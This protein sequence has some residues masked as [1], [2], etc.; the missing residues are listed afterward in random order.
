MAIVQIII[1]GKNESGGAFNS[2]RKDVDLLD[3]AVGKL[4]SGLA[5]LGLSFSAIKLFDLAKEAAMLNARYTT[6]GVTMQVVG[7][8]AGYTA[9]EMAR[10]EQQLQKN[11]IAMIES[12]ETLTKMAS[13]H[14]DLAE[15]AKLS[16]VA[17]DAAVIGGINSS[18]AFNRMVDG[19][20]SGEVEI[21]KTIGINVNF[22]QSYKKLA[23][24]LG[25]TSDELTE[26][27]KVMARTNAVIEKGA[28]IAGAYEAA[29]GT[30]GK[31]V[32]SMQR[33]IDNLKVTAGEVFQDLLIVAVTQ[34]TGALK[35]ANTEA[36]RLQQEGKLKE[37]GRDVVIAMAM[38]ADAVRIV[39]NLV[40]TVTSTA[41]AGAMQIYALGSAAVAVA[42]GDL[43]GAKRSLDEF[44]A[45]GDGWW[46]D[47]QQRW[48][49]KSFTQTAK[50]MFA[51]RDR[52]A[53]ADAARRKE[54]EER[55]LAAGRERRL[56]EE[57]QARAAALEKE[58]KSWAKLA[59][60]A[61]NSVDKMIEAE[62]RQL[63]EMRKR[64]DKYEELAA[65]MLDY[66]GK[67]LDAATRRQENDK[68]SAEYLQLQTDAANG[69]RGAV[70]ALAATE[71][72][73]AINKATAMARE[74]EERRNYANE[75]ARLQAELDALLGKDKALIDSEAKLREGLNA[76]A[77]LQDRIRVAWAEGN[78][79][80][81]NA[82]SQQIAL[83]SQLNAKVSEQIAFMES[84]K[85]LTGEIVGFINGQAVY[86][87]DWKK[88]QYWYQSPQTAAQSSM[89]ASGSPW[90]QA[91][92]T[93]YDVNGN[94]IDVPKFASGTPYVTKSGYAYIHEGEKI[95]PAAQNRSGGGSISIGGITMQI[96]FVSTGNA[97]TDANAF[98]RAAVPELRRQLRNS[99][100]A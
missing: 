85:V 96:S 17:Q 81:I 55:Q 47:M 23:Q 5:A 19:I 70:E 69:L 91:A 60:W 68:R 9:D 78:K 39:I 99:L 89:G 98:V 14:M 90:G 24:Q 16:R 40:A 20:R 87:D 74:N 45:Y 84:V 79:V 67:Y 41:I 1:Q 12:R 73:H 35:D 76:M 3:A 4:K 27:E 6:L 15:A 38:V 80:A 92:G 2:T 53:P 42:R 49:G 30:A 75:T 43:A 94:P 57:A 61:D 52:N 33:Y 48:S 10:Y 22:E 8:N 13:A 54:M 44:K 56:Q 97:Q 11:G 29:M 66:E 65:K 72:Q 59:E 36:E 58:E 64:S 83:Q 34:F 21:L 95:V 86:R 37:W 100:A 71:R 51:D 88:D 7:A 63:E 25:K 50:D 62:E 93:I 82:L 46:E 28:D 77:G 32:T 26:T 31:Q 18:D